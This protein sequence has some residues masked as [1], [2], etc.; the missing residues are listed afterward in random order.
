M[1]SQKKFNFCRT[2]IHDLRVTFLNPN[3]KFGICFFT[4][5]VFQSRCTENIVNLFFNEPENRVGYLDTKG[6]LHSLHSETPSKR[7]GKVQWNENGI[8][9]QDDLKWYET[10]IK[11]R[12]E[13]LWPMHTIENYYESKDAWAVQGRSGHWW[14]SSE[15]DVRWLEKKSNCIFQNFDNTTFYQIYMNR[16]VVTPTRKLY[17]SSVWNNLWTAATMFKS[18]Y[19]L[20]IDQDNYFKIF[21]LCDHQVLYSSQIMVKNTANKITVNSDGNFIHVFLFF[22]NKGVQVIKFYGSVERFTSSFFLP[23]PL[24]RTMASYYPYVSI[25]DDLGHLRIYHIQ[26]NDSYDLKYSST[27]PILSKE[28]TQFEQFKTSLFFHDGKTIYKI[29]FIL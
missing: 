12:G 2:L 27:L 4:V 5:L 17:F 22:P 24:A 29:V 10:K 7:I 19:V 8:Y 21:Q 14:F 20:T 28:L 3:M 13:L 18:Q 15:K 16:T 1:E 11:K 25:L 26:N 6:G 9:Y 23:I